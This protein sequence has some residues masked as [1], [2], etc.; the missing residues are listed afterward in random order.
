MIEVEQRPLSQHQLNPIKP[1]YSATCSALMPVKPQTVH[2]IVLKEEKQERQVQSDENL[3]VGRS[4]V[5][6]SSRKAAP[7]KKAKVT[8]KQCLLVY[9]FAVLVF[10]PSQNKSNRSSKNDLVLL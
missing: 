8:Q 2:N 1:K 3:R 9:K 4:K 10:F 6:S 5:Q 7:R